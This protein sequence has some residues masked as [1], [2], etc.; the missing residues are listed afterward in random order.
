MFHSVCQVPLHVS[1][2]C[3]SCCQVPLHVSSACPLC[4]QVPLHV[5]FAVSIVLSGT[6]SLFFLCVYYVV[7]HNFTFF[8][9]VRYVVRYH[10]PKRMPLLKQP[11]PLYITVLMYHGLLQTTKEIIVSSA[12]NPIFVHSFEKK[13]NREVLFSFMKP[14]FFSF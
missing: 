10:D 11:T 3:P 9:C 1:S 14:K 12:A 8:L 4:Y 2:A 6:T 5:S 7:R 13:N